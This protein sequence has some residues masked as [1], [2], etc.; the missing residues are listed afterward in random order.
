MENETINEEFIRD[1]QTL[2]TPEQIEQWKS[3]HGDVWQIN[4]DGHIAYLKAP[5]RKA[6]GAATAF[7]QNAPMKF[8]EII[9]D[10][11]WI[12]GDERIKTNDPLFLGAIA[13]L[14]E[15]TAAKQAALKKL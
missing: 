4:V 15:I 13:Q 9:L 14:G 8:N 12:Q 6:L 2:A 5:G 10:A 3:A 11:A 1:D 7:G